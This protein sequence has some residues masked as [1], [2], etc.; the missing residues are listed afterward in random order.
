MV[1]LASAH[2]PE[3]SPGGFAALLTADEMRSHL[4]DAGFD[5]L[6]Y[7]DLAESSAKPW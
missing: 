3:T 4:D 2:P 6:D 5:V 1:S 7:R